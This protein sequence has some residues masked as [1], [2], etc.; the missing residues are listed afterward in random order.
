MTIDLQTIPPSIVSNA[1]E[2]AERI[3]RQVVEHGKP[4][5]ERGISIAQRVGVLHPE[6]IRIM[7]VPTLPV[8]DDPQLLEMAASM[9]LPLVSGAGL[10]LGYSVLILEGRMNDVRLVSHECRHVA[11][12]EEAGSMAAFLPIYLQQLFKVG[13]ENAPYEKDA[14]AHEFDA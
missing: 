13:Y 12:C 5:S 10:T 4:L 11:Q 3:S 14:K 2:W 6:L 9:G 1:I 8:P 7:A